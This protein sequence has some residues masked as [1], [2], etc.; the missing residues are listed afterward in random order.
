MI[1]KLEAIKLM[2]EIVTVCDQNSTEN[3]PCR[4]CPFGYSDGTCLAADGN[5]IPQYWMIKGKLNNLGSE[6]ES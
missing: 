5:D 3:I 1:T 4:Q 6:D 2:L